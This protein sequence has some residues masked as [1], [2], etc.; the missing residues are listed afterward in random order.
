M[1]YML[2]V[3]NITS[4]AHEARLT[5][6]MAR[7]KCA[8]PVLLNLRPHS[9]AGHYAVSSWTALATDEAQ[10]IL[11]FVCDQQAQKI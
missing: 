8:M 2:H 6:K 10:I 7:R 4:K 3:L 11:G 1:N 5:N 9:A